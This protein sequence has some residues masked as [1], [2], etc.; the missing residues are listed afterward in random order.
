MKRLGNKDLLIIKWPY[1]DHSRIEANQRLDDP[2]SY[3]FK[4]LMQLTQWWFMN[5]MIPLEY[6]FE[7]VLPLTNI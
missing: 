3:L 6:I 1:K 5:Q 7:N 2:Q 4:N